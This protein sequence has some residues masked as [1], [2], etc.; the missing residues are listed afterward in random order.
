MVHQSLHIVGKQDVT[1]M[2]S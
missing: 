2:T 1:T